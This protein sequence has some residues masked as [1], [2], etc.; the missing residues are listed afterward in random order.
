M[1]MLVLSSFY[2]LRNYCV[3]ANPIL[4]SNPGIMKILFATVRGQN[5]LSN[6]QH[7]FHCFDIGFQIG[8]FGAI[9]LHQGKGYNNNWWIFWYHGLRD[10]L[11]DNW[12]AIRWGPA[13][14][15]SVLL[16]CY[17]APHLSMLLLKR[18]SSALHPFFF[19]SY[20]STLLNYFLASPLSGSLLTSC[21]NAPF[22]S[23]LFTFSPKILH[24]SSSHQKI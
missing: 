18:T 14:M 4:I 16:P 1:A 7:C 19:S 12:I 3:I 8:L 10:W 22:T 23:S 15:K 20:Y 5:T 11:T 6:L 9:K 13:Q 17:C 24:Q 2:L 21:S